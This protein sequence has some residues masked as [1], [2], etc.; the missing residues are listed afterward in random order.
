MIQLFV[1]SLEQGTSRFF[2]PL[3]VLPKNIENLFTFLLSGTNAT[4][5]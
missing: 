3:S 4:Q 5:N 1:F 2:P